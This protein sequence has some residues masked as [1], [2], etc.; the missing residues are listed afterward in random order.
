MP[1]AFFLGTSH[2]NPSGENQAAASLCCGTAVN[3]ATVVG[4]RSNLA[5]VHWNEFK[6]QM[7]IMPAKKIHPSAEI[8]SM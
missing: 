4:H 5:P 1:P 2:L 8:S 6:R 7:R 3:N